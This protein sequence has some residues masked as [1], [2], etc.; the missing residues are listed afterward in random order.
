MMAEIE[1]ERRRQHMMLVR[2]LDAHKKYEERERKREEMMAEKRA[3]QE[4]KMQK[5]RFEME[6]QKELKKPVDDMMLRDLK[7][8]PTLNRIPGLKLPGKAFADILMVYEFLHNFGETLGFDMDSLPS[9][10]TFQLALLNLDESA[11]EELLSIVH[12]LLVCA[13]DDPGTAKVVTTLMGQ[14]LKDAPITNY[15]ISEILR[16]YFS[17]FVLPDRTDRCG[18]L[19]FHACE[20]IA[21]YFPTA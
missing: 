14:K 20:S 3:I 13:I 10:N 2:A 18:K 4:R 12:H 9:L 16:L 19:L 5:K 15:N 11:G 8:L 1:R 21:F 17:S 6:L 7:P